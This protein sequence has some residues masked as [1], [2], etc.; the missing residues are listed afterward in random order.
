MISNPGQLF[1]PEVPE[2]GGGLFAEAVIAAG[3]G[4]TTTL[5]TAVG[6]GVVSSLLG[7]EDRVGW[8]VGVSYVLGEADRVGR[9][10]GVSDVPVVEGGVVGTEL[11]VGVGLLGC[12]G[13]SLPL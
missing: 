10:V 2:S 12:V 1:S 6:A 5:C 3:E 9:M 7:E 11:G 8:L 4:E 13:A